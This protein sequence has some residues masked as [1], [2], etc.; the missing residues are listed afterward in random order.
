MFRLILIVLLFSHLDLYSVE[1]S[2]SLG[3]GE[4]LYKDESKI[5]LHKSKHIQGGYMY[6]FGD[7]YLNKFQLNISNSSKEIKL[8]IPY[9]TA[10]TLANLSYDMN[11]KLV[12]NKSTNIYLG[13][14]LSN[15]LILNFFPKIDKGNINLINQSLVGVSSNNNFILDKNITLCLNI[16]IPVYY[17]S[18]SNKLDRFRF[19]N[20]GMKYNVNK[21]NY[22][23]LNGNGE[24]G[25]ILNKYNLGLFYSFNYNKII[26]SRVGTLN[27]YTN[28]LNIRFL[29]DIRN[30]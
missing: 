8:E 1:K 27:E 15:N 29:Y 23:C 30:M 4:K 26:D 7:K 17:L 19:E 18:V 25:L 2:L 28:F 3:F 11:F 16:R 9:V 20:D 22:K 24:I 21:G 12:N 6:K 14:Y 13:T 10:S 5:N